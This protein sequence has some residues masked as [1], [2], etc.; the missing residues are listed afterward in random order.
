MSNFITVAKLDQIPAGGKR[1]F[2]VDGRA[3][4]VLHHDGEYIA[5]DDACPHMGSSLS[6]GDLKDGC[7]V[8]DR[9]LWRFQLSDG[10]CLDNDQLRVIRHE[11]RIESDEIQVRWAE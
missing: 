6:C 8:C 11:V 10:H 3:V 7:I 1:G 9:H 2:Y 5:I 4:L